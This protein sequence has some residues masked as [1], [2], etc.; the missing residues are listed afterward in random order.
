M[1]Q[2]NGRG[3]PS[4]F[5]SFLTGD[6]KV[7]S[8]ELGAHASVVFDRADSRAEVH[9]PLRRWCGYTGPM[10]EMLTTTHHMTRDIHQA[11]SC[12]QRRQHARHIYV[13]QPRHVWCIT[14][15]ALQA[16]ASSPV[17]TSDIVLSS[18]TIQ[19][20]RRTCRVLPSQLP[21]RLMRCRLFMV[22]RPCLQLVSA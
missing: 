7:R 13:H 12:Q 16:P 21:K 8:P 6:A 19:G 17:N 5:R 4:C 2:P 18:L 10:L 3:L 1:I 15:V 20:E 11:A 9:I 14:Q 22:S